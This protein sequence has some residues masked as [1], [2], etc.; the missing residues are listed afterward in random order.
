[1]SP[2][3]SRSD[4]ILSTTQIASEVSLVHKGLLAKCRHFIMP[5]ESV[6]CSVNLLLDHLAMFSVSSLVSLQKM[7]STGIGSKMVPGTSGQDQ[8]QAWFLWCQCVRGFL[9][10]VHKLLRQVP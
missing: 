5:C 7:I 3:E 9:R 10:Q 4:I 1:M 6:G 8:N 2:S